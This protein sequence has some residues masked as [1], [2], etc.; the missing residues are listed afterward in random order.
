[1]GSA[2][3]LLRELMPVI[4]LALGWALFGSVVRTLRQAA[5]ARVG[6]IGGIGGKR[7]PKDPEGR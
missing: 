6:G 5:K 2:A 3:W 4:L 1:M 7:P